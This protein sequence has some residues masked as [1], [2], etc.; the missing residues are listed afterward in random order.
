MKPS[1]IVICAIATV[2]SAQ[3]LSAE[4]SLAS[5]PKLLAFDGFEQLAREASRQ[6]ITSQE[7]GFTLTVG[8]DGIATDCA[9]SRD[10]RRTYT[11][12][13]LC[14]KLMK[15]HTFEP[16]VDANGNAV[17]GTYS[18]NVNFRVWW[19]REESE[20]KIRRSRG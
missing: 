17:V 2:L 14:R 20:Q 12:I 9:L 3:G 15:H 7:L 18:S 4:S 11:E 16:A 19:F 8:A 5:K 13:S 1:K 6:R 10:F